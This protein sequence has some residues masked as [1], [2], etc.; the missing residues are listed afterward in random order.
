MV[1][2]APIALFKE[3][4]DVKTNSTVYKCA[5]C[6]KAFRSCLLVSVHIYNRHPHIKV[7]NTLGFMEEPLTK[8]EEISKK[9][10]KQMQKDEEKLPINKRIVNLTAKP[11]AEFRKQKKN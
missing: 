6:D 2:E 1:K 3:C 10:V 11:M 8:K 7:K 9:N 4:K 5:N